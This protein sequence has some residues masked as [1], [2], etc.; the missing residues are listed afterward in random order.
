[1]GM[2][3]CKPCTTPVDTTSKLSGDMG[4]PVSDPMHYRSFADALQYLTFT[5]LDISYTVQQVCLHMYD[6]REPHVTAL[7]RIL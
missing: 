2:V 6:L 7:K 1:V 4:N 3:D 5:H